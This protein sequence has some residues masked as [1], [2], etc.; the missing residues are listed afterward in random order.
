MVY[1][2]VLNN[3]MKQKDRKHFIEVV[4]EEQICRLISN[5]SWTKQEAEYIT[6]ANFTLLRK[7]EDN[8]TLKILTAIE[9][10]KP[11]II[12]GVL[13]LKV[14]IEPLKLCYV[15]YIYVEEDHRKRGVAKLLMNK[16]EE[17]AKENEIDKI[18]LN[19]FEDNIHA[20]HYYEEIGY[21]TRHLVMTKNL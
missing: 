11:E 3:E 2:V 21:Q 15:K 19:V 1:K 7:S 20:I 6:K 4:S 8:G 18:Q 10:D 5:Y 13:L 17:I 12:A 14:E 9:Q 16:A